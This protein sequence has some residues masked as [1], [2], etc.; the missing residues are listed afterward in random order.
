MTRRNWSR[1]V[2]FIAAGALALGLAACAPEPPV[3]DVGIDQLDSA[4]P[5]DVEAQLQQVTEGAMAATGSTGAIVGVYAPWA[6]Q[7]VTGLG[8]T[9]PGGEPVDADMSF[10]ATAVTRAMTCDVL[11]ALV[12]RGTVELDDTVTEWLETYPNVKDVTLE[13][14]CDSTSGI[15]GYANA[16]MPRLLAI[17]ERKWVSRELAAYGL[18]PGRAFESGK[19]FSDSDTG[20][21]LL[22]IVL[23]R[24]SGLSLDELYDEY[25]FTPL[26]M[27]ETSFPTSID[28]SGHWLGG[29][30]SRTDGNGD[31]KCAEPDDITALSPTAGA[32]AAGAVSTVSDLATYVRALAAG[33]RSYDSEERFADPRTTGN[34]Q[35]SWF[36]A[37][38]GAYQAGSLI[39]QHGSLPGY[40][41]AAYADRE[42]GL[43]VVVVLNNSRGSSVIA[44]LAAWQL[45]AIAS[46]APAA[47]GRTAP[48]AGLPWTAESLE[49][50]IRRLAICS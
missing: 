20:Y 50:Q 47:D 35:P 38:G 32:G 16:I 18:A 42:T 8:T 2:G 30:I 31:I 24:A 6:G 12:E 29:L 9:A 7:W 49:S 36:T 45:A 33:A 11:Y 27:T 28:D 40:M 48:E 4:L 26:G 34:S 23:E 3:I 37:D 22:G 41:T 19:Q 14:L 46:K 5:G 10:K 15:R 25:V 13:Q 44:R 43:T 17:P 21:V 39:G 1:A